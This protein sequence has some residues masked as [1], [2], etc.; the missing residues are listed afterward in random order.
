MASED[1]YARSIESAIIA[2]GQIQIRARAVCILAED[3]NNLAALNFAQS[4]VEAVEL[5][6]GNL[7]SAMLFIEE[8]DKTAHLSKQGGKSLEQSQTE[9]LR[10]EKAL[11]LSE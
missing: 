10:A 6:I 11:G 4:A 1:D 2:A 3:A 5:S 9:L 7:Q 8:A